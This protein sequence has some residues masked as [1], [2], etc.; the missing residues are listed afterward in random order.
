MSREQI[1]L[2]SAFYFDMGPFL[3]SE[4]VNFFIGDFGVLFLCCVYCYEKVNSSE[5]L[6]EISYQFMFACSDKQDTAPVHYCNHK[7]TEFQR[8]FEK[9]KETAEWPSRG[10][11]SPC[12]KKAMCGCLIL[13]PCRY[14]EL[15]KTSCVPRLHIVKLFPA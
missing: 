4:A 8:L 14:S 7:A 11:R 3:N 6:S 2:V 5:N 13:T 12:C 10:A 1:N 9:K 15:T